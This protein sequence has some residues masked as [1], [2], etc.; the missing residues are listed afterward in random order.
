MKYNQGTVINL[1]RDK[2]AVAYSGS[3][4]SSSPGHFRDLEQEYYREKQR[5]RMLVILATLAVVL[6]LVNIG[7]VSY[8]RRS[9]HAR[10]STNLVADKEL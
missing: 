10:L 4:G 9:R 1:S 5:N 7:Y 6:I 8:L 3:R 2:E